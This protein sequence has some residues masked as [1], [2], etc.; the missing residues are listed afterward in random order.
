M[1]TAIVNKSTLEVES[2]YNG[3]ANQSQYGGPWGRP[4]T[5]AHIQH[6]LGDHVEAQMNGA[7][8]EIIEAV[9]PKRNAKLSLMRSMRDE[10]LKE[11]DHL[12]NDLAVGDRSDAAAISTY[13]QE[14]KD[15]T[16]TYKDSEDPNEG[17]AALDAL[18]DDLSDL[19]LPVKP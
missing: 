6:N 5:H 16:N 12:V 10:K 7:D 3:P 4:E 17:T 19:S 14:L 13:R 2:Q 18:A 15:L 1:K 11:A 8:I 9:Q